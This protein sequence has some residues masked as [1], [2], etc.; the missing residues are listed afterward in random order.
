MEPKRFKVLHLLNEDASDPTGGLGVHVRDICN[1][2]KD[3]DDI[4]TV[5]MGV[6]Y[7][8]QEGGLFHVNGRLSES[9]FENWKHKKG[10]YRYI[11][12]FN[13]NEAETRYGYLTKVIGEHLFL[14]NALY[15]LRDENFDFIHLH[16]SAL[17]NVADD[18][19][20]LYRC[21]MV[22]T[23]HLSFYLN[24]PADPSNPYYMYDYQGEVSA[25][26]N[27]DRVI[28]VSES[29]ADSVRDHYMLDNVEGVLNGVNYDFLKNIKP[30]PSLKDQCEGRKLVV[31]VGR[32]VP[33]KGVDLI[34]EAIK[35][36]PD[37]F[38][39]LISTM[40]P[41]IEDISP[42]CRKLKKRIGKDKN[43]VWLKNCT[44]ELKWRYMKTADIGIMPSTHEPFGIVALEFMSL[45]TPLIV[46]Q[47]DG[48]KE[49]CNESNAVIMQPNVRSLIRSLK[50]FA[51]DA[52]KI[53]EGLKT[54]KRMTWRKVA[55]ENVRI[56][57]EITNDTIDNT[58]TICQP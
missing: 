33:D 31:F 36:L 29:Y 57:K 8:N 28:V 22:T 52:S 17:W 56:Y 2:F 47:M 42:L 44:Q 38:F 15:F 26:R 3:F 40:A 23:C 58:H 35:K 5:V 41:T 18:L 11:K 9:N 32:L 12:I 46:T 21:R 20:R 13:D 50:S 27:S 37:H 48:L 55:E 54:A 4:D 53:D 16:D 19:R 10:N 49:F 14:K 7:L 43:F 25:F 24:H 34:M 45:G 39:V 30:D 51:V 1:E 6:D